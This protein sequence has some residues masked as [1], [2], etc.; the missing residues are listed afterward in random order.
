MPVALVKVPLLAVIL[1][2]LIV[3]TALCAYYR[4]TVEFTW[5]GRTIT[6]F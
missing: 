3:A 6:L 4:P 1:I 2:I 5:F